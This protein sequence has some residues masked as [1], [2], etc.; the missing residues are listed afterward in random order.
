MLA[1]VYKRQVQNST[2]NVTEEDKK[3]S[4]II[5][6]KNTVI[7]ATSDNAESHG[8][9]AISQGFYVPTAILK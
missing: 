8:I 4:V 6:A 5:D 1:D 2:T 7:N 9:V 3:A